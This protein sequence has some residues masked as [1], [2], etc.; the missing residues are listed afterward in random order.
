MALDEQARSLTIGGT[1]YPEGATLTLDGNTGHIY[2][3]AAT[4]HQDIPTELL[5]RL[6]RLRKQ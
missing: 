2:A 6:E 3:G 1:N 4:I 5:A